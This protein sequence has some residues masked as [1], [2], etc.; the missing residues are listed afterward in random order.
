MPRAGWFATPRASIREG[1]GGSGNGKVAAGAKSSHRLP[2]Q[3]PSCCPE[4]C[5]GEAS[6]SSD[7]DVPG[8]GD[9]AV[10]QGC[11]FSCS[12]SCG[13]LSEPGR[14]A[15]RRSSAASTFWSPSRRAAAWRPGKTSDQPS[16]SKCR[17][18]PTSAAPPQLCQSSCKKPRMKRSSISIAISA[19]TN[20]AWWRSSVSP[21]PNS[22][23]KLSG[24]CTSAFSTCARLQCCTSSFLLPKIRRFK[25]RPTT[26]P[27]TSA[28]LPS[29]T[30]ITSV[31]LAPPRRSC[32]WKP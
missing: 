5:S 19:S 32:R 13:R 14:S 12:T 20:G 28:G 30:S 4:S 9:N 16:W 10:A 8:E 23:T 21:F 22:T 3:A 29:V 6:R 24:I 27:R 26:T 11:A 17:C 1:C 7:R 15:S 25:V 18:Q 2:A 31:P